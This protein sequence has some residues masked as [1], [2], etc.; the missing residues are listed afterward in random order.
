MSRIKNQH[1][2]P[3]FYLRNF[4]K[5]QEQIAVFDKVTQKSYYT[6]ISNVA[7][8]KYFYDD[9]KLDEATQVNQFLEKYFHPL[10]NRIA[11]LL[12]DL[13]GSFD[14]NE[15]NC[16]DQDS[17]I[18]LSLYLIYQF[19]RTKEYREQLNQTIKTFTQTV[20]D[21]FVKQQGG[22]PE[23]FEIVT[24]DKILHVEML[25]KEDTIDRFAEIIYNHIWIFLVNESILNFITSDHPFVKKK[26]IYHP[27]RSF[28]GL[29]SPGIEIA[30]PLSPKYCLAIAER[31]YFKLFE[32]F[33]GKLMPAN[34]D[35]VLHYNSL[36]IINSYRFVYSKENEFSLARE[37][38]NEE[39]EIANPLRSRIGIHKY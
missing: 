29:R 11:V 39:P 7:N 31:S 17:R 27:I 10:E 9:E 23:D 13:I 8:E 32:G 36:Q 24:D 16:L 21:E 25:L 1:Y 20:A 30:F 33:D 28:N 19:A 18:D 37:I 38:V 5:K 34:N 4:C 14:K 12:K 6:S 35:N 3:K 26:N 2:V 15:F 22:N